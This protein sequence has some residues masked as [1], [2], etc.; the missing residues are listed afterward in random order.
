MHAG[1]LETE[2]LINNKK[3]LKMS[4]LKKSATD[5]I[6][7]SRRIFKTPSPL[8]K[9]SEDIA[10]RKSPRLNRTLGSSS[11]DRG[12]NFILCSSEAVG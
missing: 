7:S 2:K 8:S 1:S 11:Q 4:K 3:E 6:K 9:K 10:S 5:K 12:R